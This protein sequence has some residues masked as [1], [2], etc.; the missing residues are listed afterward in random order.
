M[1]ATS[2]IAA[3]GLGLLAYLLVAQISAAVA[4]GIRKAITGDCNAALARPGRLIFAGTIIGLAVWGLWS[5]L[6]S[7]GHPVAPQVAGII[8]GALGIIGGIGVDAMFHDVEI[9]EF[10]PRVRFEL[11]PRDINAY[12]RKVS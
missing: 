2:I 10:R 8:G 7:Q 3:I 5:L 6:E 12:W 1:T 4:T 11:E 9:P